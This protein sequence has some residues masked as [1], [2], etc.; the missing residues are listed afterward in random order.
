M[1]DVVGKRSG[2]R[3]FPRLAVPL[4]LVQ[5]LVAMPLLALPVGFRINQG[6]L[7]YKQL[8][9]KD[10]HFLFDQRTEREAR[11]LLQAAISAKPILD[12]WFYR[13]RHK[14]LLITSSAVTS[15]ASFA[16]FI[17]DGIE[18]QTLGRGDRD[19]LLHE[20]VHAMMFLHLDNFFGS[21]GAIVHLPWLP[22]WWIEGL[23]EALTVSASSSVHYGIERYQ[24]LHKDFLTYEQLHNLY[25]ASFQYR[26]YSTAGRFFSHILANFK[27]PTVLRYLH[28][29]FY[30]Q[31]MPWMWPLTLIP[32]VNLMPLDVVLKRH[33]GND[34][35]ELYRQYIAAKQKYWQQHRPPVLLGAKEGQ[36]YLFSNLISVQNYA[37]ELRT[38]V[39]HDD[40]HVYATHIVFDEHSGFATQLQ[41]TEDRLPAGEVAFNFSPDHTVIASNRFSPR[42]GKP[43]VYLRLSR[44]QDSGLPRR[45][46]VLRDEKGESVLQEGE[47][48]ISD[49]YL[50]HDKII[51]LEREF[52]HTRL[53]W[54]PRKSDVPRTKHC[55][56]VTEYPQTLTILGEQGDTIWLRFHHETVQGGS[57]KIISWHPEHGKQEFDWPFVSKPLQVAFA[58]EKM[59]VLVA[60]RRFRTIIEVDDKWRCVR[61]IKFADHLTGLFALQDRLVVALY[62]PDGHVLVRPSPAEIEESSSPCR[63]LH[64][65]SSPLLYALQQQQMPSLPQ[66]LAHYEAEINPQIT[67][68]PLTDDLAHITATLPDWGARPLFAFPILGASDVHGWQLGMISVPLMDALQNE[69][70]VANLG[71]GLVSRYPT[72][73]LTLTSNRFHPT[74]QLSVFKRQVYNGNDAEGKSSYYDELGA[75]GTVVKTLHLRKTRLAFTLGAGSTR[76]RHYLG[77]EEFPEGT[78]SHLALGLA[79][80]GGNHQHTWKLRAWSMFYPQLLNKIFDYYRFGVE[81]GWTSAL[82]LFNSELIATVETSATR[83][84]QSRNLQEFYQIL[85]TWN[86]AHS[87]GINSI[88]IPLISGGGMF[89]YRFGDTKARTKVAWVVPIIEN[90]DKLF[91]IFYAENLNFSAFCNYGGAWYEQDKL[92]DEDLVFAHGYSLDL[93]LN[94]KGVKFNLGIGTGQVFNKAFE[95]YANFGF[96][97]VL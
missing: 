10:F 7:V 24:A 87:R 74:L 19:L 54:Y 83:G 96:S 85:Q 2:R 82:S 93:F 20:Y 27:S 62:S 86:A 61:K 56:L 9:H 73:D 8:K 89:S 22:T 70:L 55:P 45:A 11:F 36:R 15:G 71:Y 16:N 3:M 41:K 12:A 33:T 81:A 26:G 37:E 6:E 52:S 65:H 43:H 28:E 50:L 88:G 72:I 4:L 79:W 92:N 68:A 39:A 46:L 84:A 69:M 63:T 51:F 47:F 1:D 49:T 60:E 38:L 53:C 34:G 35:R 64:G 75:R 29:E 67:S 76:L 25:G 97:T 77:S 31:A 48:R 94:N 32:F 59:H 80:S 21:A 13:K 17:T 18:L 30:Q 44:A 90:M 40:D 14:P 5:L 57:S 23:A 95:I 58:D 42:L 66:A 78:A 91:W